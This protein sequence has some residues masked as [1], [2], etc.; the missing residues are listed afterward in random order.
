M[1]PSHDREG[2]SDEQILQELGM[3]Q[4][5]R[6]IFGGT[7]GPRLRERFLG[8]G[9]QP[10]VLGNIFGGGQQQGGGSSLFGGGLGDALKM[11]GIG[12]LAASL[13]KLA[14]ED[15]KKQTG[16]PL[17]P[18]TTMSPTGRYNIEAEIARRTGQ[19]TPN[20]VEFGLLPAGTIPELSGG[21][22]VGMQE[23]GIVDKMRGLAMRAEQANATIEDLETTFNPNNIRDLIASN[24]PFDPTAIERL[25]TSAE[26]KQ[27][28]RAKLDFSAAILR[29]ETGAQM[30]QSEID[31]IDKTYFPQIG[32]DENVTILK[33]QARQKAIDNLMPTQK[34]QSKGIGS[35]PMS[36]QEGGSVEPTQE[37]IVTGKQVLS[38]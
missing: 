5:P 29:Q 16:V 6:G 4:D 33:R 18:L 38:I 30:S 21:K 10:G 8:S 3:A 24:L 14:Y 2:L 9:D 32:D 25:L 23:G 1:F 15:A 31:Y 20:P 36:M 34:P 35:M 13:G 22:P 11:G 17:T 26:K 28:D 12:A 37:V 27:Y 7:L 19:P